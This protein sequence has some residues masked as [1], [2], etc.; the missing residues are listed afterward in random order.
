TA[1]IGWQSAGG[2]SATARP[3]SCNAKVLDDNQ[4]EEG[5]SID[6]H[7][8]RGSAL[9]SLI[10][11]SPDDMNTTTVPGLLTLSGNDSVATANLG[12]T[13]T[14][15]GQNYTNVAISTNGWLE[16]GGNTAGDSDLTNDCLPTPVHTNP[17]LAAYWDDMRTFGTAIRYGT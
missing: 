6:L 7:S 2:A 9:Q 5:W 1:T 3:I 13:L 15:E 17:F 4:A 16:F 12:F 11:H 10:A 8:P 14:L